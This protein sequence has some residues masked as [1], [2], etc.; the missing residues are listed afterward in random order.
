MLAGAIVRNQQE[1]LS[2]Y[3]LILAGDLRYGQITELKSLLEEVS[4]LIAS[5]RSAILHS[6]F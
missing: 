2:R 4:K 5:Y 6:D 3:Y 1:R